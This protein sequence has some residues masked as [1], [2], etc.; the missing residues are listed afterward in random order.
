MCACVFICMSEKFQIYTEKKMVSQ[1]ETNVPILSMSHTEDSSETN[2]L[3]FENIIYSLLST[4]TCS[5]RKHNLLIFEV[6]I[7]HFRVIMYSFLSIYVLIFEASY[8]HF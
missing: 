8:A 4:L 6:S 1:I 2:I 5:K 3:K 7:T